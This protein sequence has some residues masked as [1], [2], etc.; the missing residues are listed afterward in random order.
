MTI[1]DQKTTPKRGL[2]DFLCFAVYSANLAFGRVYKPVLDQVGL[3]YPQ[4]ITIVALWEEDNQTVDLR[5]LGGIER[6]VS[7]LASRPQ[8]PST[9]ALIRKRLESEYERMFPDLLR[10]EQYLALKR[11]L[12]Q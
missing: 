4:Y 2:G 8:S 3:T 9:K 12:S 10:A 7:I 1:Q 11:S 5:T 6:L